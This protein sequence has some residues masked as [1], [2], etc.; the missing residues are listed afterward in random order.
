MAVCSLY[1]DT[2]TLHYR[3]LKN[4]V[5]LSG[6]VHSVYNTSVVFALK[7]KLYLMVNSLNLLTFPLF[8]DKI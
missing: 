1:R 7:N 4:H 6:N 3:A 8:T 5:G 2:R